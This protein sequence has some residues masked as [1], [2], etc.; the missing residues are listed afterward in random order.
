[1][2]IFLKIK[3]FILILFSLNTISYACDFIKVPMG[4]ALTAIE[5][6]Y[7]YLPDATDDWGSETLKYSY[8]T[9]DFCDDDLLKNSYMNIFVKEKKLIGI[10]IEGLDVNKNINQLS[11]FSEVNF[12]LKDEQAKSENWVGV[13]DLS[14]GGT[15]ILYAKVMGLDGIYESIEITTPDYG[16]FLIMEDVVEMNQ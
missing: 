12:G 5:D 4:T 1:M 15:S 8:D 3:L 9:S 10:E 7:D 2:K 13:V 14:A 6:Q 11:K 16:D